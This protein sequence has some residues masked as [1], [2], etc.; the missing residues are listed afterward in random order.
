MFE[1]QIYTSCRFHL[2]FDK[3]PKFLQ[4][5]LRVSTV[6]RLFPKYWRYDFPNYM[7]NIERYDTVQG[8][9]EGVG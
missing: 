8:Q 6:I 2:T 4:V 1:D 9:R 5:I 7:F 3:S